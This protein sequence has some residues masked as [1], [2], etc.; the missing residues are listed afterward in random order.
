[1]KLVL[2][3]CASALLLL[4]GCT[5][6]ADSA[7]DK[8]AEALHVREQMW[9]ADGHDEPLPDI[10]E[11]GVATNV[12]DLYDS[13]DDILMNGSTD[14][15]CDSL[16]TSWDLLSQ[17]DMP[18]EEQQG[19]LNVML[20]DLSQAYSACGD[21]RW[22]DAIPRVANINLMTEQYLSRY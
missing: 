4:T 5:S 3:A 10:S 22:K 1:M 15:A 6:A 21:G 18:D 12:S 8:A 9:E 19:Y 16:G 11:E 13:T 20:D 2:I 17:T 7:R 14:A